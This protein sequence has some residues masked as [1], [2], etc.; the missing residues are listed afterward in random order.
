MELV[1]E[2]DIHSPEQVAAFGRE[3]QLIL[4]Y[5]GVSDADMEK[6]QLRV[7]PNISIAPVG[8]TKLGNKVEVKNINSFRAAQD[9]TA[10]EFKRQREVIEGGGKISQENRG[11]DDVKRI[12]VSQR[13]KEDAHDYRYFP[14]PDIPPF[15]TSAFNLDELRASISEL[16]Q[17]K[18]ER[19]TKEYSL[20]PAL[21]DGLVAEPALAGYFEAAA[22]ELGTEVSVKSYAN[23]ANYLTSDLRGLL[24]ET[25]TAFGALKIKPEGFADLVALIETGKIMSRQAKDILRIMFETGD[26]PHAILEREGLETVSDTGEIGKV[27]VEVLIEQPKAVADLRAGKE[28]SLQFLVGQAMKKLKGRGNPEVLKEEIK[29]QVE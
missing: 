5:L 14:E 12:T 15:E 19:F 24:N 2:P 10:F 9:A 11:W 21:V 18:R 6:G 25:G 7:E 8:S 26:D 29:K 27:V 1:T 20:S 3:L 4:R 28:V 23:L 17:A 16:P 13:S 22:S